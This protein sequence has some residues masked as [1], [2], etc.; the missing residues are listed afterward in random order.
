MLLPDRNINAAEGIQSKFEQAYLEE[1][2]NFKCLLDDLNEF[3]FLWTSTTTVNYTINLYIY[4][5]SVNITV[6]SQTNHF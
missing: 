3:N 5:L 4:I 2:S 6:A 1:E